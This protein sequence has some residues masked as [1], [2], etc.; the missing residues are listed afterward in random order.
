MKKF[1]VIEDVYHRKHLAYGELNHPD[2]KCRTKESL[3][4]L[5]LKMFL[6]ADTQGISFINPRRVNLCS[7]CLVEALNQINS[8][9]E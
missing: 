6:G 9:G 7:A 4:G 8:Q 3:C 1:C 5:Q 2:S